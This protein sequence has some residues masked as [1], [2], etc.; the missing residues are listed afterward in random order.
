[1][2]IEMDLKNIH[3]MAGKYEIKSDEDDTE[4]KNKTDGKASQ[5]DNKGIVSNAVNE[6]IKSVKKFFYS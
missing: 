5:E 3:H 1:M 6:I 2:K 4:N